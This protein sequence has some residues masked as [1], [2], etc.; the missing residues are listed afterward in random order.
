ME[1]N[2]YRRTGRKGIIGTRV[3]V[4]PGATAPGIY[5]NTPSS[6]ARYFASAERYEP[7][8]KQLTGVEITAKLNE[9]YSVHDSRL[10]PVIAEMQAYSIGEEPW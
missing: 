2:G 7:V 8:K 10:D 9:I 5:Q 6:L 4:V 1:Q 3:K